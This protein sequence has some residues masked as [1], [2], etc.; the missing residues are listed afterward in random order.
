[1]LNII[2]YQ[3]FINN[4]SQIFHNKLLKILLFFN[5]KININFLKIIK[6]CYKLLLLIS[7]FNKEDNIKINNIYKTIKSSYLKIFA[8]IILDYSIFYLFELIKKITNF[9]MKKFN[10]KNENKVNNNNLKNENKI[11]KILYL[12][13]SD[14]KENK[15]PL[16]LENFDNNSTLTLCGHLFCI[17]CIFN[18][19]KN[20]RYCPK[21]RNLIKPEEI[22]ILKN[23]G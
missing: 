23:Y 8:I 5:I 3:T 4:I 6:N 22:I 21:C 12:K 9:I 7:L 1:M 11:K 16:C 15:C 14:K 13:K 18:H 19:L 2:E 10:L 20:S 17:D